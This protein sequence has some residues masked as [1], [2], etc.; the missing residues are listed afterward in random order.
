MLTLVLRL[1]L[2][3]AAIAGAVLRPLRLPAWVA[4]VLSCVVGA[5]VGA[6][7][8][9][10]LAGWLLPLGGAVA[11][12]LLA[13][14]FSALL[15]RMGFFEQVSLAIGGSRRV[16]LQLWLLAAATTAVLNLDTAVVLLTPLFVSVARSRGLDQRA[17]AFQP[18]LLASLASSLLPVSNLTNLVVA[19]RYGVHAAAFVTNLGLPT[20]AAVTVGFLR[21]R[22]VFTKGDAPPR[23]TAPIQPAILWSGGLT[24]ASVLLGFFVGP[25]VGVPLWAVV[26]AGDLALIA[27][28]RT[29]P[30]RSV[31]FGT[32]AIAASLAVLA[33]A[34]AASFEVAPLLGN[35]NGPFGTA[36]A[37]AV[38]ALAADASNNLPAILFL[39]PAGGQAPGST[40]WA[41]LLGVN[42]GPALLV[43]GSLA[44]LLWLEAARQAGIEV[45]A[46]EYSRKGA[47]IAG[48][49][50]AAATAVLILQSL[51]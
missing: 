5:G 1:V 32:A 17:F 51:F 20:V 25:A 46:L 19:A 14:P 34:A 31:P 29:I 22:A 43:T 40:L 23:R 35:L 16:G 2:L 26:A 39:L 8:L 50:F 41:L 49:A 21:W 37:S 3:G 30:F 7:P 47:A 4:P 45:G 18:V 33:G 12:L 15:D 38:G 27:M 28:C 36:A 24:V 42:V 11:F 44:G 6:L 13:V 9:G 48:P 10:S